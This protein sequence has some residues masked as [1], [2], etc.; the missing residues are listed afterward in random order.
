MADLL[1]TADGVMAR[2]LKDPQSSRAA[3][4]FMSGV[5]VGGRRKAGKRKGTPE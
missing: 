3:L 2:F 1:S 4:A 5:P